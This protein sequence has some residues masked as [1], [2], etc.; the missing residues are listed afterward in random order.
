MAA[1]GN[2]AGCPGRA[3]HLRNGACITS[4]G[5]GGIL[6]L[7]M[8]GQWWAAGIPLTRI[9]EEVNARQPVADLS[10]AGLD[11]MTVI[12]RPTSIFH[13]KNFLYNLFARA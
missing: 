2:G 10:F 7:P 4:F 1:A 11:I 5:I 6:I 8:G 12:G 13:S 9:T 3:G